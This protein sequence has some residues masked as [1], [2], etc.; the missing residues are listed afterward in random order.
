MVHI[1]CPQD[2]DIL[3]NNFAQIANMNE[4]NLSVNSDKIRSYDHILSLLAYCK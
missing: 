3:H 1:L 2:M 4:V